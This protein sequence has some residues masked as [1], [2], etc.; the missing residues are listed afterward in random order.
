MNF[1]YQ[2][3]INQKMIVEM[4]LIG[5]IDLEDLAVLDAMIQ[6]TESG[7]PNKFTEDGILYFH[8]TTS[9]IKKQLPILNKSTKTIR[10]KLDNLV[11]NNLIE[12]YKNNQS[13]QISYYG[14]SRKLTGW[15]DKKKGKTTWTKMSIDYDKNVHQPTQICPSDYDKNVHLTMTKMSNYNKYNDNKYNNNFDG[16]KKTIFVGRKFSCNLGSSGEK[17]STPAEYIVDENLMEKIYENI[18]TDEELIKQEFL[19]MQEWINS[20]PIN[21]R[22]TKQGMPRFIINWLTGEAR[23]IKTKQQHRSKKNE[24]NN[25]TDAVN[26]YQRNKAEYF[27]QH[28]GN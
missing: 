17:A 22:K 14:F 15:A 10:R 28:R 8:I 23:K 12:R 27:K 7:K 24:F 1:Q 26:Q 6:F 21:K 18:T 13:R 11:D 9:L 25:S 3:N 4:G 5:K 19:K 20:R 16:A 2:I